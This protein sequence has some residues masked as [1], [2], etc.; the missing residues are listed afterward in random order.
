MDD[1]PLIPIVYVC[2][3]VD[4]MREEHIDTDPVLREAGISP[5]LMARPD[6]ML[7]LRQAHGAIQRYLG[8]SSLSL[9]A[10]RFGQRLDL[11]THGLLGHVYYWR[12]EF[13]DLIGSI[14][15][16]LRVRFPLM[17][18][19]LTEGKDYFGVRLSCRSESREVGN[20]MMQAFVGSFYML[21]SAA[22]RNI[23]VH[24]R[25]DLFPD[26]AAARHVLKAEINNDHDCNEVR[27]YTAATRLYPVQAGEP[28]PEAGAGHADPFTE[29]GFVVRLRGQLL[30]RLRQHHGAEEIASAMG[31]SER[32]LRRRLAECGMNFNKLRLDVRMQ[33]A[34]RY[35]TTT[36][37]S[38]ERIADYVGYSDQASFTRAFREWKGE[39][40][41][42]VRHQR[43][44]GLQ[45]GSSDELPVPPPC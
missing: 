9:P 32:T 41:S 13:R 38:I 6:A 22:I 28:A 40:P 42:Q 7:T 11:I 44:Q 33:V 23:V 16:Y 2:K 5:A 1:I 25:H 3:I 26:V 10:L 36:G 4:M 19:E 27:Y 21:G 31:M 24:C 29:H 12:G 18:I 8:L 35:L 39:S 45:A 14:L 43:R 30:S 15:A 17:V 34:L 37:I 20:F